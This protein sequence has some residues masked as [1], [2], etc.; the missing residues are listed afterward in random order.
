[1]VRHFYFC[2][3]VLLSSGH[4]A[5]V[6]DMAQDLRAGEKIFLFAQSYMPAQDIH[7]LKNP[8]DENDN[9]WYSVNFEEIL[10]TAEW[11][12]KKGYV[13]RF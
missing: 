10:I 5:I 12:F 4:F 9:P 1:M 2:K 7:I 3:S 6:I 8:A 11:Q 13:Y